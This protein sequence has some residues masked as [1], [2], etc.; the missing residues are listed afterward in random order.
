MGLVGMFRRARARQYTRKAFWIVD[1]AR[2]KATMEK[3][4]ELLVQAAALDPAN[5][6]TW[7]EMAFVLGRIGREAEAMEAAKRAVQ[8]APDEPKFHNA[9]AGIRFQVIIRAKLPRSRAKP[10]LDG[11]VREMDG[12]TKRWPSY[13]PFHLGHAHA[14]AASGA[15]EKAWEEALDRAARLYDAQSMMGSGLGTTGDRLRQV[16]RSSRDECL[17]YARWWAAL[18]D[19]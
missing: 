9:L 11:A 4:L 1:K 19:D 18:A 14:L 8:I 6:H 7:N 16:L 17:A 10:L 13:A 2:D 12:L 5:P 15:S 3:G